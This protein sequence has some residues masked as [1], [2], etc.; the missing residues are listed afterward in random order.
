MPSLKMSIH[1]DDLHAISEIERP[2]EGTESY[3]RCFNDWFLVKT[4]IDSPSTCIGVT[5]VNYPSSYVLYSQSCEH[6]PILCPLSASEAL[7]D[8]RAIVHLQV[9][10]LCNRTVHTASDKPISSTFTTQQQSFARIFDQTAL[11][12][13]RHTK[14]LRTAV[15][16]APSAHFTELKEAGIYTGGT[17]AY[18]IVAVVLDGSTNIVVPY[19]S[20]ENNLP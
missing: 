7:D 19:P 10:C 9:P 2:G 16:F 8:S 17:C 12:R 4:K 20:D 13:A 14:H 5:L 1:N 6:V 11:L 18:N 3:N 15:Y